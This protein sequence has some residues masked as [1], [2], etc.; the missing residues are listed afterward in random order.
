MVVMWIITVLVILG[1]LVFAGA[2]VLLLSSV[3]ADTCSV[4]N[5]KRFVLTS[6]IGGVIAAVGFVLGAYIL[7]GV[8]YLL[9]C[10]V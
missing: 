2:A 9:S 8:D 4:K 5:K 6:F 7:A 1:A 3:I 10:V